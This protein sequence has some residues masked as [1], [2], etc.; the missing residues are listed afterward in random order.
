VIFYHSPEQQKAAEEAKAR[1]Q[2]EFRQPI[3]TDIVEAQPF[4]RAEEYHQQYLE[5]RGLSSCHISTPH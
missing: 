4:Y 5:K 2:K 3:V 1:H